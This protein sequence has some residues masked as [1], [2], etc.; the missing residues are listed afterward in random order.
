MLPTCRRLLDRVDERGHLPTTFDLHEREGVDTAV[1]PGVADIEVVGHPDLRRTVLHA[2]SGVEASLG[3]GGE[4]RRIDVEAP[5]SQRQAPD[6]VAQADATDDRGVEREPSERLAVACRERRQHGVGDGDDPLLVGGRGVG[7]GPRVLFDAPA[8]A[9]GRYLPVGFGM[10]GDETSAG[11]SVSAGIWLLRATGT[12]G[13]RVGRQTGGEPLAVFYT[14]DVR[15]AVQRAQS[16]GATVV[17]A[18]DA[19]DGASFAHVAD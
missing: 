9:G 2:G 14:P 1:G 17:R 3:E 4:L 5:R 12:E 18:L 6:A 16:A 11:G 10:E 19:A 15:A 8:P 13:S 7:G